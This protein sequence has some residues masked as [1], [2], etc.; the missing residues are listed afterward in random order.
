MGIHR[1]LFGK[2]NNL[3]GAI[4]KPFKDI[5]DGFK[6]FGNWGVGAAED[7]FHLGKDIV[8]GAAKWT[9]SQISKVTGIFDNNMIWIVAGIAIVALILN[10]QNRPS[11]Q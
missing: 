4:G 6:N 7:T 3:F 10:N 8:T 11:P 2:K 1:K 9:D 5:G